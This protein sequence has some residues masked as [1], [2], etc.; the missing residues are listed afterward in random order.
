[1]E[2]TMIRIRP[3]FLALALVA[4]LALLA[5]RSLVAETP[6]ARFT[7]QPEFSEGDA[8][9]YFIWRDGETWKVRWTTFGAAHHF[10]GRIA[11]EGGEITS[12]RR[13]DVDTER[14]VLAPGRAPRVVRG[15]RGRVVGTTRG[16]APVVAAREEDRIEQETERLIRFATRTDDDLDGLEFRVSDETQILRF[17]L[18]IDGAV[19]AAEVEV[20]RE[21][22]VPNENPIVVRLQ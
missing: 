12:F 5:S 19:R 7:G 22:F 3:S 11:L 1:M 13:I 14:K 16:R 8:L 9:G 2:E 17:V 18:E 21:N 15:P 6:L 10:T 4:P 20:G